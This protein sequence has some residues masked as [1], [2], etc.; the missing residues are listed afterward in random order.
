MERSLLEEIST[1]DGRTAARLL[2]EQS[3]TRIAELLSAV[4]PGIA[5]EILGHFPEVRR[6]AIAAAAPKDAAQQWLLDHQFAEGTVGRLMERALAV[7]GPDLTVHEAIEALRDV[8][9]KYEQACD[10]SSD[11]APAP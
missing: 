3:D 11:S 9:R 4:N 10:A 8:I 5:V 1:T 2:A 7:F 6:Q